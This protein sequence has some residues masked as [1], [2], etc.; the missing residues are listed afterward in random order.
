[1]K[2]LIRIPYKKYNPGGTKHVII[3]LVTGILG[4]LGVCFKA[5]KA[6]VVGDT[7][8]HNR[9]KRKEPA[10]K[11]RKTPRALNLPK[12]NGVRLL[13]RNMQLFLASQKLEAENALVVEF[14]PFTTTSERKAGGLQKDQRPVRRLHE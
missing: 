12:S 9:L 10:P 4:S 6:Q 13:K 5:L 14:Q 8:I 7:S 1:M 3:L 11:T 2:V